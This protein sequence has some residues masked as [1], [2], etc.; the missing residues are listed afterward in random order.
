MQKESQAF[1]FASSGSTVHHKHNCL[2][3]SWRSVLTVLNL[4]VSTHPHFLWI[5]FSADNRVFGSMPVH[6][7]SS[8]CTWQGEAAEPSLGNS[9]SEWWRRKADEATEAS[10]CREHWELSEDMTG[11]SERHVCQSA[12]SA[13]TRHQQLPA[14][15]RAVRWRTKSWLVVRTQPVL[16]GGGQQF[17]SC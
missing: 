2:Y 16:W 12:C 8:V 13:T 10:C 5:M 3:D 9:M 15:S 11:G 6:V 17:S 1:P 14:P 4:S 7:A